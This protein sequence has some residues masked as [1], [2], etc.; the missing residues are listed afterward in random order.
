MLGWR[1]AALTWIGQVLCR[2]GEV[3]QRRCLADRAAVWIR[4]PRHFAAFRRRV[5]LFQWRGGGRKRR[6]GRGWMRLGIFLPE[7]RGDRL[8]RAEVRRLR[9]A[10]V[11]VRRRDG[12]RFAGAAGA[13]P[14]GR[15]VSAAP[16]PGGHG[17]LERHGVEVQTG[18]PFGRRAKIQIVLRDARCGLEPFGAVAPLVERVR[19]ELRLAPLMSAV[20]RGGRNGFTGRTRSAG[21]AGRRLPCGH[22]QNK[23]S[24]RVKNTHQITRSTDGLPS[25]ACREASDSSLLVERNVPLFPFPPVTSQG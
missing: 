17:A 20:S 14:P 23:T 1:A 4:R 10:D 18:D 16:Q 24:A 7:C 11:V 15:R 9:A 6:R 21:A 19:F 5:A 3:R 2:L 12:L 8:I 13:P 22:Q 25:T